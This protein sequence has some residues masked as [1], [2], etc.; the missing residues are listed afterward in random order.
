MV[1]IL[2]VFILVVALFIFFPT[3]MALIAAFIA[4]LVISGVD[5]D[6]LLTDEHQPPEEWRMGP[7]GWGLYR[8]DECIMWEDDPNK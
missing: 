5:I 1:K 3:W 4:L 8:G 7:A 6:I 2:N